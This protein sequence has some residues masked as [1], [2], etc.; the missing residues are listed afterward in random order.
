MATMPMFDVI[1]VTGTWRN[2]GRFCAI[3]AV[4]GA[5]ALFA[6]LSPRALR[7]EGVLRDIQAISDRQR[8]LQVMVICTGDPS[9]ELR[10]EMVDLASGEK[11]RVPLTLLPQSELPALLKQ[12]GINPNSDRAALL[13]EGQRVVA[14]FPDVDFSTWGKP[15]QAPGTAVPEQARLES[16]GT[17]SVSMAQVEAAAAAMLARRTLAEGNAA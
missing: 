12:H 7:R 15:K 16:A 3:C 10:R 13:F 9:P 5:P 11:L 17:A 2:E 1:P 4:G 8:E 6:F 14:S